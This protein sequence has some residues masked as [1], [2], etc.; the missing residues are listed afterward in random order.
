ML[1]CF[2]TP[3]RSLLVQ[4]YN[5]VLAWANQQFTVKFVVSN[6]IFGA[7]QQPETHEAVR[8]F[9][10]GRQLR[11]A[12]SRISAIPPWQLSYPRLGHA[13]CSDTRTGAGKSGFVLNLQQAGVMCL[14][15][16]TIGI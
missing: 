4:M 1:I 14:Q 9:L 6:S 16:W 12:C 11:P 3:A 2:L 7:A 13:F 10:Q 8:H 15:V 5:P